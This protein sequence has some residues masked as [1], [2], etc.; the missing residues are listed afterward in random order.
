M[1]LQELTQKATEIQKAYAQLNQEKEQ[2]AWTVAEYA[3][4]L[5][6]D[7]GDLMKLIMAKNNFR[8]AQNIDT[9][10]K[11]E[12]A[13]CLWSILI[14]AKEL[15]IDLEREFSNTMDELKERI[16]QKDN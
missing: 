13:D 15:N 14:I 1:N 6:G 10:L 3:Q 12:L 16:K 5:V 7:I 8:T 2:N 9:Q 11:H 4:G